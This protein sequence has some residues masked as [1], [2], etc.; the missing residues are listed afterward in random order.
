MKTRFTK[1]WLQ[2][3]ALLFV[4]SVAH[5][6]PA[7]PVQENFSQPELEQMLAPI[8]LYPDALL[9]TDFDGI[10]LSDRSS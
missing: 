2:I 3:L 7:Q 10:N 8:A 5:A 9:F 1:T 4:V 6:Q